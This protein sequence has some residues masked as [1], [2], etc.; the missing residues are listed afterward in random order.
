MKR[1]LIY[2][3][4]GEFN[5]GDECI[6]ASE[7]AYLR[8]RFPEALIEIVT[9]NPT[10]TLV[11]VD[12]Q[13]QTIS[14]FPNNLRKHPL[15]NV[16]AFFQNILAIYHA[17]CIIVGGGGM[18]YDTEFGQSFDR[19]RRTWSL[20]FFFMQLLKKP[21]I[22]WSIGI[23]LTHEHLRQVSWWFTYQKAKVTVRDGF[24]N[25]LLSDIG[26]T[27]ERIWDP[28]FLWNSATPAL[29]KGSTTEISGKRVGIALRSGYL[30]DEAE[31]IERIVRYLQAHGFEV[32]F[33]SHSFHPTNILC[34]DDE[35]FE[36][37]AERFHVASTKT[38]Q[39]TLDIYPT[40]DFVISMR[41]HANILS[42]V[43]G[44]PFYSISYG[45]KTRVLLQEL[46]LSFIQDAKQFQFSL[47]RTQFWQLIEAEGEAEFA[48]KAK[49]DTIRE[50]I[51]T[52]LE[53]LFYG[54]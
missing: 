23:D 42:V 25:K 47:F 41:L 26:V 1:I 10:S 40:L 33:L 19:L 20:R 9:Y 39:E 45:N 31:N 18:F 50:E 49:Y 28:V 53:S 36:A 52:S 7:V 46:E 34:N 3:A 38:M 22:F 5:L 48:I 51:S 2:T 54:Y 32:I 35:V 12:T 43:H 16:K 13:V 21:V 30:L 44:V 14:Y 27:S 17:D 37:D 8:K 11:P 29:S 4:T 6:L 24:S 15:R